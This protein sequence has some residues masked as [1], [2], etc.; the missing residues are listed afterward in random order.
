MDARACDIDPDVVTYRE[1][2]ATSEAYRRFDREIRAGG[3]FGLTML[4]SEQEPI[5]VV[6]PP[7][8]E[9][10]VTLGTSPGTHFSIDIG[11]GLW[12]C[13]R[14]PVDTINILPPETGSHYV[15][16]APHS[17]IN[18]GLP[19]NRL[20]DML[21]RSSMSPEFLTRRAGKAFLNPAAAQLI[22]TM[23]RGAAQFGDAASL[24]TDGCVLQL[25]AL[26]A[27]GEVGDA[28]EAGPVGDARMARV[29]DYVEAHYG[30]T[31]SIAELADVACLS[32]GH[33]S[34]VFK[35]MIGEP[36]WTYVAR[37]RCERAKEMLL[38]T[39]L[40]IAEIAYCCGFAHQ[41]HLTRSFQRQF[42]TTP[43]AARRQR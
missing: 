1:F 10:I 16:E 40:A 42:G 22:Q 4:Q 21:E 28:A 3:S 17:V 13:E 32:P 20:Q 6:H 41:S 26:I 36:V 9:Y 27:E 2:H 18:C 37:R 7:L 43:A 39:Q 30:E 31:L 19:A 11:E 34:R 8:D 24:H 15:V 25:L 35:A 12:S 38:T 33:F 14:Y 23:W 5:D 29:L